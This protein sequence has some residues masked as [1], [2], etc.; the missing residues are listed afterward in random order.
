ME[1]PPVA[2]DVP[3]EESLPVILPEP[4]PITPRVVSPAPSAITPAPGLTRPTEP[5]GEEITITLKPGDTLWALGRKYHVPVSVIE[6][7][8]DIQNANMI[9]AGRELII[10]L[11]AGAVETPEPVA[12]SPAESTGEVN[13]SGLNQPSGFGFDTSWSPTTWGRHGP[14]A[15]VPREF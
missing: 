13:A 10:P 7:R 6:D 8:N 14:I 5:S 9:R 11:G 1:M 15:L 12:E 2:R 4:T 3:S